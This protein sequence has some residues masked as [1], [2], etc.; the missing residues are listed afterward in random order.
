MY[1]VHKCGSHRV[2]ELAA[3]CVITRGSITQGAIYFHHEY[4][5]SPAPA[6]R[7]L[8][9]ASPRLSTPPGPGATVGE[10]GQLEGEAWGEGERW[11]KDS[12]GDDHWGTII[13]LHDQIPPPCF[14]ESWEDHPI[15]RGRENSLLCAW[16][17]SGW[18]WVQ[19]RDH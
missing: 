4:A 14:R 16:L 10:P 15:G 3:P 19:E 9:P 6:S 7:R 12:L 17:T 5:P 18:Q 2:T 13:H 11:E 8:L 1:F